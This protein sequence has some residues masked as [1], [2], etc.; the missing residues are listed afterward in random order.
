MNEKSRKV[1]DG[2]QWI[3]IHEIYISP[4]QFS[5]GFPYLPMIYYYSTK[6]DNLPHPILTSEKYWDISV[7]DYTEVE[8]DK[9]FDTVS[10]SSK[11]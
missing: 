4:L 1:I 8:D 6:W 7:L 2:E 5:Q 3:L 10:D 9:W 11:I